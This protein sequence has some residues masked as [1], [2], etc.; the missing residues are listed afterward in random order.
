VRCSKTVPTRSTDRMICTYGR[1]DFITHTVA[2]G[3]FFARS[4]IW[5]ITLARWQAASIISL[6]S[7]VFISKF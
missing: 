4:S 6:T 1:R 5:E 2:Y 3:P 7:L